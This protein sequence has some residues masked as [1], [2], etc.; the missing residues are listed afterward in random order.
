MLKRP[1]MAAQPSDYQMRKQENFGFGPKTKRRFF[2]GL[3]LALASVWPAIAIG[4]LFAPPLFAKGGASPRRLSALPRVM[5]W[6]W[7]RPEDLR[8]IDPNKVGIAFLAETIYLRNDKVFDRPRLQPLSFPEAASL[9]AVVRIETDSSN[10]PELSSDQRATVVSRIVK[11]AGKREVTAVQIDF[12]ARMR[13]RSFY[14]DL[15][16]DLRREL[17]G[18]VGLS[19]TALASW[20][21]YDDWIS[22]LPIDEA[23]PMLF[24]MGADDRQ[25]RIRLKAGEDFRPPASRLSLGI[26]TDEP[27]ENLP[28]GRRIYIFH[29]RPWSEETA[30]KII[31]EV[32]QWQ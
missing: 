25:I 4:R 17:P 7:E 18:S 26:S 28:S 5:L 24:R 13:E 16:F 32:N 22:G 3:I 15:L 8:F 29:P 2:L 14:R 21:L 11:A 27:L 10:P 6:A 19:I 23:V 31:E 20:C 1:G 9:V 12:D 30:R